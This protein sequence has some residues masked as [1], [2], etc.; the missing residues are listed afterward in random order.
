MW[1]LLII[2]LLL[3]IFPCINL[4]AAPPDH[5]ARIDSKILK[6]LKQGKSEVDVIVL[7]TGYGNYVKNVHSGRPSSMAEHQAAVHAKQ[8][9]I[10]KKVLPPHLN[11]KR[12][13]KNIPG[14]FIA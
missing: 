13:F 14:F 7:L 11:L 2:S 10:L 1:R 8:N 9:K 4:S 12:K 3:T 6:K 5:Q